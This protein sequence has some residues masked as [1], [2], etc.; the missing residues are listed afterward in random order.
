MSLKSCL[1]E[2]SMRLFFSLGL[3]CLFVSQATCFSFATATPE[4]VVSTEIDDVSTAVQKLIDAKQIAGA[5]VMISHNNE[6][7][8]HSSQGMRD[9]KEKSPLKK[10][11]IL[12]IYS[13]TKPITSVAALMLYEDGK[14]E[15]DAPVAQYLPEFKDLK[16]LK[17][18]KRV[19]LNQPMTVRHLLTHTAGFTYGFFS[20]TPV[21]KLYNEDHPLFSKSNQQMVD[22]LQR[23]PLL[24]QPGEKWHYS[25][26]TDV[27]G[28]LVERVSGEDLESFMSKR[29]F[30]PLQMVDTA[31]Y[32]SEENQSRFS[33]SYG[34]KQKLYERYSD[35]YFLN[36]DRI[37]SGGGGLVSTA[38][39]YMNFCTMLLNE[40]EFQ[41]MRLL[42]KSTIREMINNQLPDGV[43][44]YGVF[45]F[46]LGVQVQLQDWGNRA[47][48][49]EYGWNGAA[50]THF[51]ISPKDDLI[52]I[53][54]AQRQPYSD[55]LKKAV[56][57]VIYKAIAK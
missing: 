17:G 35:S 43:L 46:G 34:A 24:F 37:L 11:D 5:I 6:I 25:V 41:G 38:Q 19:P 42:K 52:V 48:Q 39:D 54:L 51:W 31:F 56:K 50:S 1:L 23:Y 44:A 2:L 53:A 4:V 36:R 9:I 16:V 14:L 57:P 55:V 15:L 13:M 22:K 3:L 33:S 18:K 10:D 26:A 45:G 28:V 32:V 12:R 20:K 30:K 47:H 49:G 29:I 40:G 21:D 7:V 27:L 8:H